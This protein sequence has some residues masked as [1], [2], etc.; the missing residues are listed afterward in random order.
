M[1]DGVNSY[2]QTAEI[3]DWILG[4]SLYGGG[5]VADMK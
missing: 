1:V 3:I 5:E 2:V 4:Q